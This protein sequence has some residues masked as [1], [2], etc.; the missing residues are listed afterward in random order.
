MSFLQAVGAK[1][2]CFFSRKN[3]TQIPVG[4]IE[5]LHAEKWE[6]IGSLIW[7]YMALV[8]VQNVN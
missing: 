5:M 2:W 4:A 1:A 6:N 7:A 8:K 3:Q